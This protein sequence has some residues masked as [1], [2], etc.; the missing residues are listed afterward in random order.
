MEGVESTG[1]VLTEDEIAED[2]YHGVSGEDEVTAVNMLPI[3]GES[4]AGEDFDHPV[5]NFHGRD[6]VV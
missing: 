3:Y 6:S 5:K 2:K 1:S 4:E